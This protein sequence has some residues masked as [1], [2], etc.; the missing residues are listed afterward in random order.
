M[1]MRRI[2][3]VA[4]KEVREILRDR[5]STL[6]AFL[7]P[8]MFMF[9]FG[10][11]MARD[12][13]NIPFA[14]LDYDRSAMSRDYGHQYID[15]RYFHF[16]GYLRHEREIERLLTKGAVRAVI[17]IPEHF[18]ERMLAGYPAAV[19]ALLDGTFTRSTR[20]TMGYIEAIHSAAAGEILVSYAAGR[21]GIPVERV[22]EGLQPVKLEVRYVHN[23][24]IRTIW[25]LAPA[26]ILLNLTLIAPLLTALGVVRERETGAIYN[27]Y[28][29]TA[30]RAEFLAGKLLPYVVISFI[31][32]LLLWLMAVYLFGAP[33]RGSV[34]L[35]LTTTLVYVIGASGFGL[36]LSLLVRTQAAALMLSVILSFLLVS[37]F[38]GMWTP[39]SSLTGLNALLA[40]LLPLMYYNDIIE[41]VFLKG[42]GFGTLGWELLV[43]AV[44]AAAILALGHHLFRK[45]L[46]E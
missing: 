28:A 4:H 16:K 24:E 19:Q 46:R 1:K 17:L 36:L 34:L 5:I 45:R 31:D 23:E 7:L 18:Q 33:F 30:S 8:V 20:T 29:S 26:L 27:I 22:R 44:Q 2:A 9:L 41:G 11:G 15:S 37:Q 39:V 40:H 13:E 32:G 10:Y 43:I 3:A 35:F 14:I 25:A 42:M 21:L 12:A 38:S 6:L